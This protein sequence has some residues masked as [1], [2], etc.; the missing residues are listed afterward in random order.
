MNAH[1]LRLAA[2]A[3]LLPTA[4]FSACSPPLAIKDGNSAS[5]TAA[6][7]CDGSNF[8]PS[9]GSSY[10]LTNPTSTLTLTS[11]TTAYT[12]GNLIASSATAGSVAV[13]SF[14]IPNTA[15]GFY[16]P[17]LRLSTNDATST[18]WG[19]VIVQIDLWSAAPTFTN[20]DRAAFAVA[21]GTASHLAAYSCALS[22][23]YGDGAYAECAPQVG[24]TP[25]IRLGSG[26]SVYWSAM[27][28]TGS[29]VT[30]ASGAL[31]LTAE[32]SN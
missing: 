11:A 15:G 22:P 26:T 8:V 7:G 24:T 25:S 31:T 13:P 18:A 2:L 1:R 10:A 21:T 29:G 9:H 19:G 32:L 28:V 17:R 20:G 3:F 23:E 5:Q 6:A 27:A 30:E 4:A 16:A 12:A 14:S